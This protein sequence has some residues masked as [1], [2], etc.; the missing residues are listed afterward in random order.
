MPNLK[1]EPKKKKT[2]ANKSIYSNIEYA[3]HQHTMDFRFGFDFFVAVVVHFLLRQNIVVVPHH[4]WILIECKMLKSTPQSVFIAFLFEIMCVCLHTY[5]EITRID[6]PQSNRI[7]KRIIVY[8]VNIINKSSGSSK[9]LHLMF[10][11]IFFLNAWNYCEL[12]TSASAYIRI[13]HRSV[14]IVVTYI[15]NFYR[16]F[17]P[18]LFLFVVFIQ[19]HRLKTTLTES[20]HRF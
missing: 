15:I 2:T 5:I 13:V 8:F 10:S 9:L 16:F 20:L 7:H 18:C 3:Q 4:V 12:N 1:N 11:F 14:L 17:S 19:L 6:T